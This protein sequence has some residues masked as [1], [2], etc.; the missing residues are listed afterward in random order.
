MII[1]LS[2]YQQKIN[3]D[4][5]LLQSNTYVETSINIHTCKDSRLGLLFEY[6]RIYKELV[7]NWRL[8]QWWS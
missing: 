5:F 8:W 4:K 7:I 1:S 2:K 6:T 3:N